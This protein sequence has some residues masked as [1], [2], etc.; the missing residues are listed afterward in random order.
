MSTLPASA[1]RRYG[2]AIPRWMLPSVRV[3]GRGD[4]ITI[5]Q[6][7]PARVESIHTTSR[8]DS[9]DGTH[10]EHHTPTYESGLGSPTTLTLVKERLTVPANAVSEQQVRQTVKSTIDTYEPGT[11][12]LSTQISVDAVM[13]LLQAIATLGLAG[14][15]LYFLLIPGLFEI[16]SRTA[17][18]TSFDHLNIVLLII[19]AII[20]AILL[21]IFVV[22]VRAA[23]VLRTP[24]FVAEEQWGLLR[25]AL[26]QL[27]GQEP[28]T[29]LGYRGGTA[30]GSHH[31]PER[32]LQRARS[33]PRWT[34]G[35]SV[36][37]CLRRRQARE[38]EPSD[39]RRI[40]RLRFGILDRRHLDLHVIPFLWA[41]HAHPSN[42]RRQH[43]RC[44]H[45]PF[46]Q[47]VRPSHHLLSQHDAWGGR[48]ARDQLG[49]C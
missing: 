6:R 46:L 40:D 39:P 20:I 18:S 21:A 45:L 43:F 37:G 34:H 13:R 31:P 35:A 24:K 23:W 32:S 26:T 7:V 38:A 22:S 42:L 14:F 5:E 25:Q 48:A 9:T 36:A 47:A 11:A 30:P 8:L 41:V 4:V 49:G 10:V 16:T 28:I 1:R 17:S 2:P 33:H 44:H 3:R 19:P 29:P 15:G 27:A 12:S